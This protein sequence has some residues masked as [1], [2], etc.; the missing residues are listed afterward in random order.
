MYNPIENQL[1]ALKKARILGQRLGHK[2]RFLADRGFSVEP[3]RHEKAQ[4]AEN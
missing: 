1:K 3:V 4:G 2:V